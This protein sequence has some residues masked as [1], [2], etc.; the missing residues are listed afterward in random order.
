VIKNAKTASDH[1]KMGL[2]QAKLAPLQL[3][4]L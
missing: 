3:K 1:V 2:D 4:D